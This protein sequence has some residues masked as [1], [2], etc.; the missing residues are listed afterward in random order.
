M[1]LDED[2]LYIKIV[3][4]DTIYNFVVGKFSFETMYS[5]KYLFSVLR[6]WN[7]RFKIF[8]KILSIDMVYAKVECSR[9]A[10]YLKLIRVLNICFKFS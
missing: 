8:V 5:P 10:F 2:R 7:L 9:Y 1:K 6:F 3:D 4:L